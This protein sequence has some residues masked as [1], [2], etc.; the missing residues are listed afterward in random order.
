[1]SGW[2][3]ATGSNFW[4]RPRRKCKL[5][6]LDA[7]L[8][9]ATRLKQMPPQD[10]FRHI[11]TVCS[12]ILDLYRDELDAETRDLLNQAL[13]RIQE[14][15]NG[16]FVGSAESTTQI[17]FLQ[18]PSLRAL[19]DAID[20]CPGPVGVEIAIAVF[21][22]ALRETL[23]PVGSKWASLEYLVRPFVFH[24]DSGV[25]FGNK[26]YFRYAKLELPPESNLERNL[27]RILEEIS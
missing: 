18:I 1:M 11:S 22:D 24:P 10:Y 7:G 17:D 6:I 14:F 15:A 21:M 4:A 20:S 3:L 19:Q 16:S 27:H 26:G 2:E 13:T 12:M 8:D 23:D 5:K 25:D 9:I